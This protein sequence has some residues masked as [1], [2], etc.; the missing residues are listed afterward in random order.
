MVRET[1]VWTLAV[2]FLFIVT[3]LPGLNFAANDNTTV[4][5]VEN[6]SLTVNYSDPSAV[7]PAE[8]AL[9]FEPNATVFNASGAELAN[10][11]DYEWRPSNGTVAWFNTTA[12]TD[13]ESASITYEYTTRTSRTR[14]LNVIMGIIAEVWPLLILFAGLGVVLRYGSPW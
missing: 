14:Q 12:T 11:T 4:L 6:E 5:T 9:G 13:G 7:D 3:V 10:G 2:V 8:E 1:S